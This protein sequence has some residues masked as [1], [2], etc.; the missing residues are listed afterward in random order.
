MLDALQ[1]S[2]LKKIAPANGAAVVESAPYKG[3]NKTKILLG[4][5]VLN[6]LKGKSVI[7]FGCGEGK[8]SVEL[9]QAGAACVIGLD[10]RESILQRARQNAAAAGVAEKCEF[11][12]DYLGMVDAVISLDAF[13]H[14][15]DPAG[16]LK[17]MQ[18]LLKPGGVV[19]ISFGPSWYHPRGGHLFSMIPWAHIIFSEKAL[20]RW[21]NDV[22]NDGATK[23][24][25]VEGGLNQ[26]TI[27]RFEQLVR[28]TSFKVEYIEAAPIRKLRFFHNRLTREFFTAVVRC[29]L[30]NPG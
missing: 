2:I 30:I 1:Y 26:M 16:V 3:R 22:R 6:W 13:E 5:E 29:K 24:S 27:A 10:N 12:T 17:K 28:G 15:S 20:I 18:Q 23:F 25:E 11:V 7:D 14:F 19:Y 4:E 9:A 8:E 21:R